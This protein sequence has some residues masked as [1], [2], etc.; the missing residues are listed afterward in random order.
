MAIAIPLWLLAIIIVLLIGGFLLWRI[1]ESGGGGA[2]D[3]FTP[4]AVLGILGAM[5]A[6][7][8]GI[9]LGKFVF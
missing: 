4:M 1:N 2:Y 5:A 3:F 6:I 7:I 8:V 9:L